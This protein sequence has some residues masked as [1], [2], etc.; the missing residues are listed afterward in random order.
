[1]ATLN[2]KEMLKYNIFLCPEEDEQEILVSITN[3][4]RIFNCSCKREKGSQFQSTM[5]VYLSNVSS[6][7]K[8]HCKFFV[9]PLEN[10][11]LKN[12]LQC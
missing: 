11:T 2:L 1:M 8:P 12:V 7:S 9:Q 6:M 3:A 10:N 5:S 4:N